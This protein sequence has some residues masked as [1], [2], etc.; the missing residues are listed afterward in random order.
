MVFAM[1]N[2]VL[3]GVKKKVMRFYRQ[4]IHVYAR[5]EH[6]SRIFFVKIIGVLNL[7]VKTNQRLQFRDRS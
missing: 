3:T 5:E 4:K 2:F 7:I 6:Y 1:H